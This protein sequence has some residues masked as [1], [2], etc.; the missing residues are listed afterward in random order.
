[1]AIDRRSKRSNT[2][3]KLSRAKI[4]EYL[5]ATIIQRG[6]E[7]NAIAVQRGLEAEELVEEAILLLKSQGRVKWY[8]RCERWGELDLAGMDY[9]IMFTGS[10]AIF[11]LQ[12]KASEV[13]KRV[14]IAQYGDRT[15]CVVMYPDDT[16]E[17]MAD[18]IL[19]T[20]FPRFYDEGGSYDEEEYQRF[21]PLDVPPPEG[22]APEIIEDDGQTKRFR[23]P[24]LDIIGEAIRKGLAVNE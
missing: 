18:K 6:R 7:A 9:L 5:D 4:Q 22:T 16:V 3:R 21:D 15:P 13:G 2:A 11:S 8:H 12:A 24:S 20:V 17:I 1:M 14:H 10:I 19:M 23:S